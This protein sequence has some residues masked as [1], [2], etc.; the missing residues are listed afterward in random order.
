M[1][2]SDFLDLTKLFGDETDRNVWVAL[3]GGLGYLHR[4]LAPE[5]R[6]ALQGFVRDLIGPAVAR[7]GWTRREGES[8]LTGQLRGTLIA[9]LGTLGEDAAVQTKAKEL[10]ARYLNDRAAVDRDVVPA[11]IGIVAHTGGP[12]EYDLFVER[13]QSAPTPQEKQR[14]L[15]GL[16]GFRSRDLLQRTLDLTLTDKVRTQDAPFVINS[17]LHNLDGGDLTWAFVK[18]HWDELVARFPGNTHVRMVEGITSL[19]TPELVP[20]IEQFFKTHEIKQGAKTLQQ[21]LE[22]LQINLAFRQREAENL[23]T[24]F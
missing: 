2:V 19:S 8:E 13:Y 7:L 1:P 4:M 11:V 21:H 10:H 5:R 3:I 24:L 17:A 22:R 12:A 18:E 23:A 16:A 9:A 15:F 14:Y 20:D 6:P